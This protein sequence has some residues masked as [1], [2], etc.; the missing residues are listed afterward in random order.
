MSIVNAEIT[1][2]QNYSSRGFSFGAL[3]IE[4]EKGYEYWKKEELPTPLAR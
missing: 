4:G 1:A 2:G 3:E